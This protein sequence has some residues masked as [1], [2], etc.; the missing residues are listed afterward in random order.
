MN[1]ICI[2]TWNLNNLP[3]QS[4]RAEICRAKMAE[5]QA[6]VWI[7]TETRKEFCP[8]E[9]YQRIA[10]SDFADGR[11]WTAIWARQSFGGSKQKTSDPER[12]A[13]ARLKIPSGFLLNVYGTVL[14]WRGSTWRGHKSA[15]GLAFSEALAVQMADWLELRGKDPAALLCV[16]GDFNQ[17]LL[18]TGYY[19][20]SKKERKMLEE[21]LA[22]A[23]LR[24][25]TAGKADPVAELDSNKATVDHICI[26]GTRPHISEEKAHAWFPEEQGRVLSDHF[27]VSV[28]FS[29]S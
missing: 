9:G 26:D 14:P 7:L 17:D 18:P 13:C 23:N 24:C 29:Y 20:G 3:L 15:G 11:Y 19:Y 5:I 8:G 10:E 6:D 16:A 4:A 22:E 1:S 21:A 2:A 12:T 25:L 27:G 28:R